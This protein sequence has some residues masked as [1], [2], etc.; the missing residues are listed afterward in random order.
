MNTEEQLRD[1]VSKFDLNEE[2]N[3]DFAKYGG[4]YLRNGKGIVT[5]DYVNNYI[6]NYLIRKL[7]S[8]IQE[9][10]RELREKIEKLPTCIPDGVYG[11]ILDRDDVL[12][13]LSPSKGKDE[14]V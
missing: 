2:F 10:E 12:S 1:E 5:I 6:Q 8:S 3:I 13:L 4:V 7:T 11:F 14:T 9:R